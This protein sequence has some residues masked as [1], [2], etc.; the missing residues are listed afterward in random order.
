[1]RFHARPKRK[2]KPIQIIYNLRFGTA[3]GIAILPDIYAIIYEVFIVIFLV[4]FPK[5][6]L[7]IMALFKVLIAL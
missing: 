4:V 6:K 5:T 2:T 7:I 3:M 1:M